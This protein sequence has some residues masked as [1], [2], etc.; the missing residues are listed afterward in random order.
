MRGHFG[1]INA[2]AYRPDGRGF[3]TGGED[4]YVRCVRISCI[5]CMVVCPRSASGYT[6]PCKL[7]LPSKLSSGK[8]LKCCLWMHCITAWPDRAGSI[9]VHKAARIVTRVS[10]LMR[11]I[12]SLHRISHCGVVTADCTQR[13]TTIICPIASSERCQ[14]SSTTQGRA[15][16]Q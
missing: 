6:C 7:E 10:I 16:L 12:S 15:I 13:L 9:S 11:S 1:P 8:D 14:F 2:V 3:C 4:G 5:R